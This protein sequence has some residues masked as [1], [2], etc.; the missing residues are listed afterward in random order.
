VSFNE[1]LVR[2]LLRSQYPQLAELDLY[3]VAEGFDNSLWRLGDDLAVRLPRRAEAV[4]TTTNEL[5]WLQE[6]AGHVTLRTPLPLLAGAPSDEFPWPWSITSWIKGVPGDEVELG[7]NGRSAQSLATFLR[8]VHVDAPPD[9]PHNPWRGVALAERSPTFEDRLQ[10]LRDEVDCASLI[11]LWENCLKAPVWAAAPLWLHGD[12][13][14]GNT[15]Y[16]DGELVGVIDFGDL[17][18]GD[19]ATDLAGGLMSLPF[20]ALEEYF[21]TYQL[22]DAA[23]LQRT[24]GWAALFGL[25]MVSLGLESRP[26]YLIVGRRSLENAITLANAL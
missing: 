19:P 26:S 21:A 14:P 1:S 8:E 15:L 24:V 16:T 17:C 22:H 7:A 6:V 10:R 23:T 25:M 12:F 3:E 20:G 13:H 2:G 11:A 9:A 5:R 18:A 4:V